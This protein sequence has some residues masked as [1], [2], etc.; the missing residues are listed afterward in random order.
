M[1]NTCLLIFLGYS[2]M[3]IGQDLFEPLQT[4]MK[5]SATYSPHKIKIDGY[6][7]EPVWTKVE[8]IGNFV[9]IEPNQGEQ[10]THHTK[11][12]V[13]YNEENLYVAAFCADK[14][15]RKSIRVPEL[16]R[17]FNFRQNDTF[18]VGIDG[19]LDERNSVTLAVNPYGAQKDYLSYDDTYFDSDWNGLWKVR[20]RITNEGWYAEFEIPWKTL[21]YKA[22]SNNDQQWGVNFIRMHRKSNEISVWSVYPRSFG[23]NRSEYFGLLQDFEVPKPK[24]NI[25]VSPYFLSEYRKF[26]TNEVETKEDADQKL[27]LDVRWAVNPTTTINATVNT[28]FAQADADV[29]VNNISRFSVFFP[30]KRQF[31]LENASLFGT[32]LYED[33]GNMIIAPFFS[34][35]IGLDE[36]GGPIPMDFGMRLVHQSPTDSYGVMAIKEGGTSTQSSRYNMIA[37]Y[38]KNFGKSNRIGTLLTSRWDDNGTNILGGIDG[39]MRFDSANSLGFMGSVTHSGNN[40]DMG[41]GGHV[42][43]R[44]YSNALNAW[45]TTSFVSKDFDPALGFVSR[46]NVLATTPGIFANY[47]GKYLPFKKYWRAFKPGIKANWYHSPSNGQLLERELAITPIWIEGQNGNGFGTIIKF[48]KQ[49]LQSPLTLLGETIGLGKYGYSRYNLFYDTDPS[50][51]LAFRSSFEFGEFYDGHLQSWNTTFTFV[52]IPNVYLSAD[53]DNHNFSGLGTDDKVG[54]INL[55]TLRTK[56]Y[57]NPRISLTGIYQKN[58]QYDSDFFNIRFSWEYSPLSYIHLVFNSNRTDV[59]TQDQAIVKLSFLKQF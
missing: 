4:K 22:A 40:D 37:R 29:Q 48:I 31:F 7:D 52:P 3:G 30:E 27:G 28:D 6:L 19:F 14:E 23:F 36:S 24:S 26:N 20:T 32:G 34:R 12:W 35:K 18:A 15:G 1:K 16:N 9:Q 58:S 59:L 13:L 49:D 50:K 46:S 25:Q 33:A 41:V 45:W 53:L 11:V 57:L 43:Y 8:P 51:R 2:I 10:A 5:I 38:S 44:H 56:L 54:H 55:Y 39:F 47:R 17:D 42:Q 21:K